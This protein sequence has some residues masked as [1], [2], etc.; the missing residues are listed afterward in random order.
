MNYLA[1]VSGRKTMLIAPAG[2]GKTHAIAECLKYTNGKQ[3]ILTHTHAGV[4]SIK[5]KIKK[6]DIEPTAYSIETISSFAQKYSHAFYTGEDMPD[7]EA[8]E[9]HAFVVKKAKEILISPTVK[10]VLAASY[11]GL[12]VDEYQDCTKDQHSM[13]SALSVVL[14]TH[15]LGDPM[16]GIFDFNGDAVDFETDLDEFNKFQELSIPHRWYREGNSSGLGDILKGYRE[17]LKLRQPISLISSY[18]NGLYVVKGKVR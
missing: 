16:Q 9:Y 8:K 18:E 14:P 12:F 15:I 10:R 13:I 3:L 2:Y 7:Q 1:F 5:D 4:A 11:A 17:L 6:S